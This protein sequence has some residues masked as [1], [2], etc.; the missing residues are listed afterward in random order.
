MQVQGLTRL[1]PIAGAL[2]SWLPRIEGRSL[3]NGFG[4]TANGRTCVGVSS[5][6][7]TTYSSPVSPRLTA[8][9]NKWPER[10]R[11]H[12]CLFAVSL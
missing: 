7:V 3:P 10:V 2:R 5:C 1:D 11:K 12:R 9:L 6:K 4:D 8:L